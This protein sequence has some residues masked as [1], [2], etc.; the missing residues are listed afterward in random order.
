MNGIRESFLSLDLFSLTF[1]NI[2]LVLFRG[3]GGGCPRAAMDPPLLA[4]Y[5]ARPSQR[6]KLFC[7]NQIF[8]FISQP[9]RWI[10]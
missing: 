8:L 2:F 10:K 9:C 5:C 3:G 6:C 1:R 4:H 7:A